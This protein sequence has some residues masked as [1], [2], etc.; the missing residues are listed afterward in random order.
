MVEGTRLESGR[1]LIAYREFESHP[2]RQNT[3]RPHVADALAFCERRPRGYCASFGS[4]GVSGKLK[5]LLVA[6]AVAVTRP[7]FSGP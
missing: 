3:E 1:T 4:L 2:L 7:S 6:S 5:L